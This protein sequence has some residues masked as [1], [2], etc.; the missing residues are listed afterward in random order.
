MSGTSMAA[1]HV[2]AAAAL[3]LSVRPGLTP[4][5]V[6]AHLKHTAE[7]LPQMHTSAQGAGLLRADRL[8][9]EEV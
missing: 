1:P 4:A 8:L 7:W 6:R 5:A 3:L 9:R 2:S